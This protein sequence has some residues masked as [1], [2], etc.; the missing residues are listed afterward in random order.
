MISHEEGI[1]RAA[2]FLSV[3][4][5]YWKSSN[6]RTMLE[7]AFTDGMRLIVPY[8]HVDYLDHGRTGMQLAGNLPVA[9]DLVTGHCSFISRKE[10]E[11]FMGRDLL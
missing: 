4:S 1:E 11:E 3:S 10:V 5:K 8:D 7:Q 9:A 2:A 6:V